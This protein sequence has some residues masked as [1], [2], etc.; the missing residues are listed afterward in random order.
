MKNIK[1]KY[2]FTVIRK[3]ACAPSRLKEEVE[4][5]QGAMTDETGEFL[6]GDAG[7]EEIKVEMFFS[8][9]NGKTWEKVDN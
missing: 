6:Y 8:K 9:D 5:F 2:V 3:S 7:N 1:L 4:Y